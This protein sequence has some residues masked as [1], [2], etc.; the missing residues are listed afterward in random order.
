MDSEAALD[1]AIKS[2]SVLGETELLPVFV[3]SG[4]VETLV[5]LVNHANSDIADSAIK[6]IG[7]LVDIDNSADEDD[8]KVFVEDLLK[9]H[10]YGNVLTDFLEEKRRRDEL[11]T[12]AVADALRTVENLNS[13]GRETIVL[14]LYETKLFQWLLN[15]LTLQNAPTTIKQTIAELLASILVTAPRFSNHIMTGVDGIDILLQAIAPVRKGVRKG[16]DEEGYFKDLFDTLVCSVRTDNAIESFIQNEGVEL[17]FILI[18]E[19]SSKSNL[20]I[21]QDAY[22]VL[23]EALKGT[24]GGLTA[25]KIAEGKEA[26]RLVGRIVQDKKA[27]K[28]SLD[29]VL[30]VLAYLFRWLPLGTWKRKKLA[31]RFAENEYE[32]LHLLFELRKDAKLSLESQ[33][34]Q[35]KNTAP[36]DEED[37]EDADMR[38]YAAQLEQEGLL[39]KA[40]KERLRNIDII[41]AW[42]TIEYP[43]I[44]GIVCNHFGTSRMPA[45]T[46]IEYQS[47]LKDY[48]TG[49]SVSDLDESFERQEAQL[50]F[51]MLTTMIENLG[52]A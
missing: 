28:P 25:A 12:E 20:W 23:I 6:V 48:I 30:Q 29:D 32:K 19:S 22:R 35:L 17:M 49:A 7:E 37:D 18:K 42:L 51:D 14:A 38:R 26:K 47:S 52:T 50:T 16:S 1:E 24:T 44:K 33:V 8:I 46:L 9:S 21:R 36:S 34:K 40:G 31:L 43:A 2:L 15:T 41:L 13:L 39:L 10:D 5:S 27:H 11:D 45:D 4:S 3:Q